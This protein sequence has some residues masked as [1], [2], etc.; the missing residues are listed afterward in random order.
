[1][2]VAQQIG[3]ADGNSHPVQG[4][5]AAIVLAGGTSQRMGTDKLS[6]RREGRSVVATVIEEARVHVDTVIIVGPT[7]DEIENVQWATEDPPG[8]G[9]LAGLDAGLATLR[10]CEATP[11]HFRW[12]AL[13]AGDAP[14]GPRAIPDLLIAAAQA[15]YEGALL[16]DDIGRDHPLCAVYSVASLTSALDGLHTIGGGSMRSL[17]E[18]LLLARTLDRWAASADLDTPADARREGFSA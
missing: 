17:T 9:P 2:G 15:P 12:V 1:M 13:L 4:R 11:G 7:R 18:K 8:G 16:V 6:M 14:R 3:D 10:T 5:V